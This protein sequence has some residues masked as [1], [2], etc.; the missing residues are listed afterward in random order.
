[1]QGIGNSKDVLV[2]SK[3]YV[4]AKKGCGRIKE[5]QKAIILKIK[6]AAR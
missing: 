1:M 3:N 4:F 5:Y 2:S 6:N